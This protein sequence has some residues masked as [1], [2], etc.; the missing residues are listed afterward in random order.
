MV[1]LFPRP[2][3]ARM[4]AERKVNL[5]TKLIQLVCQEVCHMSDLVDYGCGYLW[6]QS[7][8][9]LVEH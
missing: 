2:K 4:N 8:D 3:L 5:D 9:N 7:P 1:S 6:V